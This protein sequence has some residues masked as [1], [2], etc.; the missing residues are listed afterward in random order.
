[1]TAP[2]A[3]EERIRFGHL[4]ANRHLNN[5]EFLRFFETARIEYVRT[6]LPARDILET[7]GDFG[8]IFAECHINYRSPGHYDELLRTTIRA[9]ELRR[10]SFRVLFEMHVGERLLA[11]GWGTLVGF[12]Y[13]AERAAPLPDALR[14]VLHDAGASDIP[15][16]T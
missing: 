3:V 14:R 13:A 9:G 5:V 8:M 12:D 10:S 11:E 16:S 2:F 4:D 1:M 7:E 6:L 15:P